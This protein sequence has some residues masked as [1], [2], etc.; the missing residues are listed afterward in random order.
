MSE[1]RFFSATAPEGTLDKMTAVDATALAA[2]AIAFGVGVWTMYKSED[3]SFDASFKQSGKLRD[4]MRE[5]RDKWSELSD[6]Q[7]LG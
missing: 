1:Q 6:K 3:K 2:T 5:S 4:R 7:E